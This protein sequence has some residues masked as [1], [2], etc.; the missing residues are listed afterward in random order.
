M[1]QS[2]SGAGCRPWYE[3]LSPHWRCPSTLQV[4]Y[5]LDTADAFKRFRQVPPK[6]LTLAKQR[7]SAA[8]R[9]WLA[10]SYEAVQAPM[11]PRATMNALEAV[12]AVM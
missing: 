5:V 3:P 10:G 4:S 1:C 11:A 6:D 9:D 8:F 2:T 7:R 12:A